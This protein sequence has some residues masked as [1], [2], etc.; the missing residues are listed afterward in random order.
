MQ[1]FY[2]YIKCLLCKKKIKKTQ[3]KQKD[4]INCMHLEL[5]NIIPQEDMQARQLIK[6]IISN[7]YILQSIC[8]NP[9]CCKKLREMMY[10]VFDSY[11][12]STECQNYTYN[13]MHKYWEKIMKNF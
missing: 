3:S 13:L 5:Y 2:N 9:Y 7:R 10:C 8:N 6:F 12:C 1:S 11:Y 4:Y